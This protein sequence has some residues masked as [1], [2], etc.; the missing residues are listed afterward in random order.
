MPICKNDPKRKYKGDEPSPKGFGWCA[1]CEKEGKSRKGRDGNKWVVKKVSNGSLRWA[2]DGIK[3]GSKVAPKKD[4]QGTTIRTK[5]VFK[6]VP[7]GFITINK[8]QFGYIKQTTIRLKSNLKYG[9]HIIIKKNIYIQNKQ[10]PKI[11]NLI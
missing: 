10:N 3:K 9:I 4:K 8:G 5:L 11:F 1:H 2:K 7:F 6:E